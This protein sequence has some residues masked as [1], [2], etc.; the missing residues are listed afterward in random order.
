LWG[1]K[2]TVLAVVIAL[3]LI[4][5]GTAIA[6][7]KLVKATLEYVSK[8]DL[9]GAVMKLTNDQG[10]SALDLV[11]NSG[12]APLTVNSD[13]GTATNLSA[14]NLDGK[15]STA[16]LPGAIY[17]VDLQ[18]TTGTDTPPFD[19][20]FTEAVAICDSGDKLLS[21]GFGGID[22]GTQ[23]IASFPVSAGNTWVVRWKHDATADSISVHAVCADFPP[24]RTS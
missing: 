8:A 6:K 11:V 5:G 20:Q 1:G 14:D 3:T 23:L 21:G 22:A 17:Q 13:A 10:G 12:Q 2:V 15:D 18:N 24:L 7:P 19:P 9:T 16:F 4:A